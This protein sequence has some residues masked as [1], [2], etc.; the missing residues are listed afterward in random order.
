VFS[1][2]NIFALRPYFITEVPLGAGG[3]NKSLSATDRCIT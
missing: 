3:K 1:H 2:T